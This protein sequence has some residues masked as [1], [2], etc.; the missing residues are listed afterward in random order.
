MATESVSVGRT[1]VLLR[2]PDKVLFDD[3]GVTKAELADH[4]RAVAEVMLPH[5]RGHPLAL[6][7]F[8]DGIGAEGF[9]QKQR[10]GSAPDWVGH[11]TVDREQGGQITMLV[12]DDA[13]TLVYLAGQ[14][15]VTLHAWPTTSVAPR[16]P[17]RMVFDL[18]PSGDDGFRLVRR[19]ARAL[20]GLLDEIRLPSYVM[21]TGSRG[22]H[23][24]V[25]LSGKDD[26]DEVRAVARDI[27][28]ALAARYPDGLTT[29][30][31][32]QKRRGRLFVDT[33]RNAY[34]Q[35]SVAPYS[36]RPRP[37]AP[38]ATPLHWDE[39]DDDSLT[40]RSHTLGTIPER[41][42]TVD[43]PWQGMGRH[44]RSLSSVRESVARL[45]PAG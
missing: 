9:L 5:I 45:K 37:G 20:H 42:A 39:L 30:V 6:E 3:P 41:L 21:T 31:R 14:A 40:A 10:P 29:E 28:D 17:T 44:A 15:A 38:V 22:L 26:V 33:L 23:V 43:D 4:Y 11:A 18:D 13:A 2:N 35:H 32:K 16:C 24:I 1:T 36:P 27:A 34:A 12:C 19:S 25:P 7:R 8:P